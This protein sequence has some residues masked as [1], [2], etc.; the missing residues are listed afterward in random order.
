MSFEE[1]EAA[2]FEKY[3]GKTNF[4]DFLSMQG[5]LKATMVHRNSLG[6]DG[7]FQYLCNMQSSLERHFGD[8]QYL[9]KASPLL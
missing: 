2:I 7:E 5:E 1:K 6:M 9:Q 4:M 3:Q 8:E